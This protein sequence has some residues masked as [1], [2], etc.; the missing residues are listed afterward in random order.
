[1]KITVNFECTP[2]E[3]RQYMG[4][5]D[6]QPMQNA[7]MDQIQQQMRTGLQAFVP[8][9]IT[10]NTASPSNALNMMEQMQKA[11]W[12]QMQQNMSSLAAMT[13]AAC[14]P[15]RKTGTNG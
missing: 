9:V 13:G 2:E 11:F 3:A 12:G 6:L 5:P 4:L 10:A 7:V 8:Q 1:M 15:G 14:L